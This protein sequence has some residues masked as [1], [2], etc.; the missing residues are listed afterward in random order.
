MP[1]ILIIDEA[2]HEVSTLEQ[3][4]KDGGYSLRAA[5]SIADGRAAIEASL[6]G[7]DELDAVILESLVRW[8]LAGVLFDGC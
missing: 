2:P 8:W 5:R 1:T 3:A 4:L 7:S 6:R